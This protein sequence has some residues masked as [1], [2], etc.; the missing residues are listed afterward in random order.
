MAT[1]QFPVNPVL[2]Q[3]YDYPPYKYYWDGV[4][5]K[6]KGA[7]SSATDELRKEVF[8]KLDITN[9]YAIE[10]LR[11]SYAE[12][13]YTVVSGSF[14]TGGVLQSS[15]DVLLNEDDGKGYAWTGAFP[16]TVAAGTDP[17]AVAG[18]V[19]RSD[20]GLRGEIVPSVSEALRRS[21]ADGGFKLVSGSFEAGG[22]LVNAND[23]LL[24][25]A[26]GKAYSAAGPFP[27]VVSP[28]TDP[29]L[30]GSG[31]VP[32]TDLSLRGEL[33]SPGGAAKV[34]TSDG[35]TV[36]QRLAA[37]PSK[38]DAAISQHNSSPAAHPELSAFITAEANRAEAAAEVAAATG[39]I[40]QTSAAGQVDSALVAGDY[41]WVV[42]ADDNGVFELWRKGVSSA[43][44]MKKRTVSKRYVDIGDENIKKEQA[45]KSRQYLNLRDPFFTVSRAINRVTGE[46]Y[47]L[48][49]IAVTAFIPV[50]PGDEILIFSGRISD[51][52]AFYSQAQS[53]LS[54]IAGDAIGMPVKPFRITVPSGA[55]FVRLNINMQHVVDSFNSYILI[56]GKEVAPSVKK[57]KNPTSR[58]NIEGYEA[59]IRGPN[60]FKKDKANLSSFVERA[61][62]TFIGNSSVPHIVRT[63]FI[64]VEADV[65]YRSS[66]NDVPSWL[67]EY[68]SNFNFV[69]GRSGRSISEFTTS[70][71]T[72]FVVLNFNKT[73]IDE[74]D[75]FKVEKTPNLFNK[76]DVEYSE[77]LSPTGTFVSNSSFPYMVRTGF[78]EIE[79]GTEY[80]AS[81]GAATVWCAQ[82][83]EN[84]EFIS[85]TV[86]GPDARK[87]FFTR[88]NA[89]YVV[90][91]IHTAEVDSYFFR[92]KPNFQGF[93]W[94]S[95]SEISR[96]T[97][98][99][100]T[101]IPLSS[102]EGFIQGTNLLDMGGIDPNNF[103]DSSNGNL[104][105]NNIYTTAHASD[106]MH[107]KP[108][109]NYWLSFT[110]ITSLAA[111]YDENKQFIRGHG[112]P[113]AG[114]ETPNVITTSDRTA[115][116]RVN[117]NTAKASEFIVAEGA[118][119]PTKIVSYNTFDFLE[120]RLAEF[121][122]GTAP[123]SRSRF[124]G[125]KLL[126]TGDSITENNFHTYRPWHKVVQE[127]L[128]LWQVQNDAKSGAGLVKNGGTNYRLPDWKSRFD[129]PD[130]VLNMANMNDGTST[131][132][133]DWNWIYGGEG[134][135]HK[136]DW[137]TVITAENMAD[138]LWFAVRYCCEQIINMYPNVPFGWITS[139]PRA[140][141]AAKSGIP[142]EGYSNK[143]WG[144]DGWFS[145]WV[146][147]IKEIC[148]HYSIPVL[149]LYHESSL[150]PWLPENNSYYFSGGDKIHPNTLGHQVFANR[151]IPFIE[152]YM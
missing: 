117:I 121:D 110:D 44:D 104:V 7:G 69:Q 8:P 137:D 23:V 47:T 96:N 1:I 129:T 126:V 38:V 107:V 12:A 36:E 119:R 103:I 135:P 68:D 62:G 60:L 27:K 109:T 71:T 145:E 73:L 83:N 130:F 92:K 3:E 41:F 93:E 85:G 55:A 84:F 100:E 98:T 19:V 42:S 113:G 141:V 95:A 39:K 10:A 91:N 152:Q 45:V 127:T 99:D 118:E 78:I 15:T 29:T 56:N 80:E 81:W 16:K 86:L 151:I 14:G 140:Q 143:C 112:R 34:G 4:K 35:R 37:L 30:P 13:G 89:K 122:G 116:L 74:Y 25:K 64:P 102:I 144:R 65:T 75:F 111:E 43:T 20:A 125:K 31:Y 148:G 2:N 101:V 79:P 146:D 105:P 11:R 50:V 53:F 149:D 18:F 123:V 90:L 132:T 58:F 66:W 28:G 142:R 139:Q 21:Y 61:D 128:G 57:S 5:W 72:S 49:G 22:T 59:Y 26:S 54:G 114:A 76:D 120:K 40:Y 63:G 48:Q 46:E 147:V 150:R 82:Y 32:R 94:L 115:Y 87:V 67:A 134:D 131:A 51:L 33:A 70:P 138:S 124:E 136:G 106:F 133:G 108:N 77:L 97:A 17:A 9:T 6:T 24:H 52:C 88:P